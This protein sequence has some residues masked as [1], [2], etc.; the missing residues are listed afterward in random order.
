[1]TIVIRLSRSIDADKGGELNCSTVG[2][3]S[4]YL[5]LWWSDTV[6]QRGNP[7]D[8]EDFITGNGQGRSIDTWLKLQ[9]YYSHSN[10]VGAVD[11]LIGLGDNGPNAEE[12]SS[13]G[14]PITA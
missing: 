7:A 6:I 9:G 12:C 14:S 2:R 8:A 5:N 10:E 11:S 13:F 3:H 4:L 1:M